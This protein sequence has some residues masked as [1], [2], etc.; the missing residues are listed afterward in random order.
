M[1]NMTLTQKETLPDADKK[2]DATPKV[3]KAEPPKAQAKE[4][5]KPKD[6]KIVQTE[7]PEAATKNEIPINAEKPKEKKEG[8]QKKEDKPKAK[9]ISK[10]EWD[11]I[12]YPHLSEKSISNVESQNKIIFIVKQSAKRSEIKKAV[13]KMF[14]VKVEKVNMLITTS[15]KKKAYVRL[16]PEYSAADIATRLGMM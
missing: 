2:K 7:K 5:T 15:G 13:E 3:K 6:Q 1:M 16:K 14:D 4:E 8:K 9:D 12:E 10:G 11:I